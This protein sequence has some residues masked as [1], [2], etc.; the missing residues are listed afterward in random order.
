MPG[1]T[2]H[3]HCDTGQ[4]LTCTVFVMT[5]SHHPV[6]QAQMR[7]GK[8]AKCH[9]HPHTPDPSANSLASLPPVSDIVPDLPPQTSLPV[10]DTPHP[11]IHTS[12]H[13]ICCRAVTSQCK[14]PTKGKQDK[15]LSMTPADSM[16]EADFGML[17]SSTDLQVIIASL[18]WER[19]AAQKRVCLLNEVRR[20]CCMSAGFPT[21]DERQSQGSDILVIDDF[22]QSFVQG[23]TKA[24]KL[25]STA[26]CSDSTIQCAFLGCPAVVV[27]ICSV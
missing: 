18:H 4:S 6:M 25:R 8:P 23:E 11:A 14:V 1:R 9:L 15:A 19:D 27:T 17:L 21:A 7:V 26:S 13:H 2:Q 3:K 10:N 22:A 16:G 24:C 12:V 5:K 20:C